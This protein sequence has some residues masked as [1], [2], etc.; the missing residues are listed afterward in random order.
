MVICWITNWITCLRPTARLSQYH[1]CFSIILFGKENLWKGGNFEGMKLASIMQTN[2]IQIPFSCDFNLFKSSPIYCPKSAPAGFIL[3]PARPL[4][5]GIMHN[6]H[7]IL[8]YWFWLW[9]FGTKILGGCACDRKCCR[10]TPVFSRIVSSGRP[11]R[12]SPNAHNYSTI[13]RARKT[14][15]EEEASTS[16]DDIG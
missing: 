14:E 2:S 16:R 5:S 10:L 3:R 6:L 15:R 11:P 13:T 8:H 12:R 9:F 1:L 4:F 7:S